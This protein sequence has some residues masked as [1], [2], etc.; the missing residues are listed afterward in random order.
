MLSRCEVFG[1]V[2]RNF[3]LKVWDAATAQEVLMLRG[4]GRLEARTG[5]SGIG[6]PAW[7]GI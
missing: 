3:E 7:S 2:H 6:I 4:D 1:P 5:V